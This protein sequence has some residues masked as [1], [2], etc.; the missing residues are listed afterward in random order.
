M[1]MILNPSA[2]KRL[3][4]SPTTCWCTPS[5]LTMLS[6]L[7]S[8]MDSIPRMQPDHLTL[9]FAA[10]APLLGALGA[11]PVH[12]RSTP[13]PEP[14]CSLGFAHSRPKHGRYTRGRR[15]HWSTLATAS[16]IPAGDST[17]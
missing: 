16:P 2:S 13:A 11:S 4:I 14:L 17:T 6:V 8:A 9:D 5:G 7:D 10:H 3:M 15:S 1:A 12:R